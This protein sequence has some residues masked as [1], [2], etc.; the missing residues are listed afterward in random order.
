MMNSTVECPS[1]VSPNSE[2]HALRAGAVAGSFV[3]STAFR[4]SSTSAHEM[5][6]TDAPFWSG[7]SVWRYF[8][9]ICFAY[10]RS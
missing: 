3:L 8:T 7:R 6:V 9:A 2:P 4:L 1:S 10:S 5:R